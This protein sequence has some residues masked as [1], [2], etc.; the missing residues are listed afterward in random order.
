MTEQSIQCDWN[1]CIF[2]ASFF[3]VFLHARTHFFGEEKI[4]YFFDEKT[5][6]ESSKCV[7]FCLNNL[8]SDFPELNTN[9]FGTRVWILSTTH[10]MIKF[11]GCNFKIK[12]CPNNDQ[13][14]IWKAKLFF[15]LHIIH[16][17]YLVYLLLQTWRFIC[18]WITETHY[19]NWNPF[20]SIFKFENKL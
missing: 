14:S 5:N 12:P 4:P 17:A 15:L 11:I 2:L 7:L 1:S 13:H 8:H 6:E 18:I 9:T 3:V 19:M 16:I 20:L 10:H